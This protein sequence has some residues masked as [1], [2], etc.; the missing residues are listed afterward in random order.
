MEKTS[1]EDELALTVTTN[2]KRQKLC[3][4]LLEDF[5]AD[6]SQKLKA[7][8]DHLD[9]VVAE[10]SRQVKLKENQLNILSVNLVDVQKQIEAARTEALNKEKELDLLKNE[11]KTEESTLKNT[12]DE[13]ESK[14]KELDLL[15]SQIKSEELKK[16]ELRLRSSV[17]VK[18]E[19]KP[20]QEETKLCK[21]DALFIREFSSASLD[22]DEVFRY[23]RALSNPA[24][25][26]L[27]LVEGQIRDAQ[28]RQRSGLQDPVVENLLMFLEELAK[29]GGWDK[30]QMRFKAMQVG[31]QWKEMIVIESPSSSL[32]ALAFLLFI[33][34]YEL[35]R[36]IDQEETVLLATSVLHYQQGPEL[37]H[38]LGLN[39]NIPEFIRELKEDHQYIPAA[40]IICLFKRK[41]FSA[42]TLLIKEIAELRRRS[43]VEKVEKRDVGKFKAIVE[44]AEGMILTLIFQRLLLRSSCFRVKTQH[45]L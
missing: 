10:R 21:E 19:E 18:H 17:L 12:Q 28:R 25:F 15:R 14:K 30:D 29:T 1:V 5:K 43:S 23:L 3:T 6:S 32:E 31:T 4:P 40:R 42:T 45:H 27:D 33:V 20:I 13:L 8:H 22:R 39:R 11:I 9:I 7:L 24:K 34:G 16:K 41:D 26:V 35:T 2:C 38:L 36:L 37:F 44:L